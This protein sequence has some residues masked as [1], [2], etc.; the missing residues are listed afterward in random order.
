MLLWALSLQSQKF[1]PDDPLIQEPAPFPIEE[2]NFRGLNPLYEV[3]MNQFGKQGERHPANGVI[4]ALSAEHPGGGHGR[5]L[6]YK[7]SCQTATLRHG[8]D[9]GGAPGRRSVPA[10]E[11]ASADGQK[12]R[13][14][15][16]AVDP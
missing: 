11:M 4:P 7:P 15:S 9:A 3:V 10:E 5:P 16:G 8:T 14:S 2:A 6:V 12:V 13:N 1:Y